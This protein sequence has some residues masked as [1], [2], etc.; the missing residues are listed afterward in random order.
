[1]LLIK[2][3]FFV[4]LI[5]M[6][7]SVHNSVFAKDDGQ[8]V[9]YWPGT[10]S[11]KRV[12][13]NFSVSME[14]AHQSLVAKTRKHPDRFFDKTPIFIVGDEYFFAEPLK[15][16]ISLQGFYVNGMTGK[17]EYRKSNKSIKSK[18]KKIPKDAYSEVFEVE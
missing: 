15:A 13:K 5:A 11:F 16:E 2:K 3:I 8:V 10:N 9:V 12:V 18:Q 14:D 7:F 1:M 17:I 6:V 4:V